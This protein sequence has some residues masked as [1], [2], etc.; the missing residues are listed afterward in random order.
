MSSLALLLV[1]GLG[2]ALTGGLLVFA[3]RAL[4]GQEQEALA[5]QTA[6]AHELASGLGE[7]LRAAEQLLDT[8]ASLA[9]PL[10][11]RPEVEEL[12][13][14]ML[15]SAP[16][17]IV[18]GMGVWFEPGQF[19]PGVH[20]MGPYIHQPRVLTYEWST[21][22]YDY[23]GQDWY[24]QAWERGRHIALTEP[25]FDLDHTYVS[26]TRAFFDEQG[27]RR[28]IVSVDLILPMI[29]EVVRQ[30]NNSPE[31]TLY[32][33]S[34][35]GA[36]IAHPR[37]E[38][39]L[40]WARGR[41]RSPRS[42]AELTLEDLR[43][44]E[45]ER[46]LGRGWRTTRVSV[47]NAGW[48]VFVSTKEDLLFS[49]VR[50]QRWLLVALGVLLWM[51][52]G[53]SGLVMA[54]SE[55]TRA[56]L[57]ALAERQRREEERQ[58]L[59]A[60]VQ[61][62]SAELQAIIDSMVEAVVV[63]DLERTVTLANR[64]ALTLFGT[65]ASEGSR[66]DATYRES[67]PRGLE[68]QVLAFSALPICRALR[69]EQVDDTDLVDTPPP[70]HRRRVLRFNA[71]PIRDESG[72]IVAAV[73]V[74]RD[75]TQA[76]ELERLQGEF[77]KM[78]A[79]EL[80]TPL[81]VMKSFAQ[82]ACRTAHPA[83]ALRRPLEGISR[84]ADRMD[85][86]VRTLLDASQLQLGRL[87]FEKKE[88]R[89]RALV[90]AAAASTAAHHPRHPIHVR[91]GPDAWVLG[92]RARLEQVLTELMD[93][94][95]RYSAAGSPVEVSLRVE[96][97]EVEVSIQDEGIGIAEEQRERIFER[98][99]RAHAGTPHDRGG[100]GLG[101]YL[102]R[103]ILLLHEGQVELESREGEGTHVRV[104]LPRLPEQRPAPEV[105]SRHAREPPGA[106]P[107]YLT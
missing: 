40:A 69:G 18:Y 16:E 84:G 15:A 13:R 72:H 9:S 26:L 88:L 102:S 30:A 98:F 17:H 105:A 35:H 54:R 45:H 68:G 92:D 87:H 48:R 85:R 53:A 97:D 31:E 20:Y 42:L 95:A 33:V 29:G 76:I 8:L 63:V 47:R 60:Q 4:H 103:G 94:A 39:L 44:W 55:R 64:A 23:P 51:G 41:G 61:R 100:M 107:G 59:L 3:Q 24:Q 5:E 2:V 10:R 91:P 27:R 75:I 12:L 106:E 66:L 49:D 56:L 58:R 96:G 46:G 82:L 93:N 86:V 99:Y 32:L 34:P 25:Y 7:Q 19:A 57:R 80:K 28:G 104:R 77:V 50:R 79:H 21:P 78:A 67:P 65:A 22:S 90:E 89:L 62:R 43:T 101:L 1:V 73:S 71:A 70:L 83:P 14:R 36:L 37:G 11:E 38:E 52:L 6:R 81:A 74:G